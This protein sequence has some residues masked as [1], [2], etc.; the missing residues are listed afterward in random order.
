MRLHYSALYVPKAG[1]SVE[2]YEDSFSRSADSSVVAVS[3]GAGSA[4]ESRRWARMLTESFVQSPPLGMDSQGILDWSSQVAKW[5]SESIPW[6]QL[7]YFEMEKASTEGSAA[8]LVGLRFHESMPG[9]GTWQCIALGDSCVFQVSGGRLVDAI[10]ISKSADFGT[11]PPLFYTNRAQT[12]R[13]L[14]RLVTVDNKQWTAGDEF[15]LLTDA[16]AEWFLREA[17]CGREPW[18]TLAALNEESFGSFVDEQRFRDLLHNDDV[19]VVLLGTGDRK[20]AP[21][22]RPD[23]G[24]RIP[25]GAGAG[26]GAGTGAG[27]GAGARAGAGPGSRSGGAVASPNSTRYGA[28]QPPRARPGEGPPPRRRARSRQR[29]GALMIALVAGLL[30]GGLIG[31]AIGSGGTPTPAATSS[32]TPPESPTQSPTAAMES[33]ANQFMT[34]LVNSDGNL[35]NYETALNTYVAPGYTSQVLN[36]LN[37]NQKTFSAITSNG[38]VTFTVPGSAANTVYV[39]ATE[40]WSLNGKPQNPRF[41]LAQLTM[42]GAKDSW[43]V[44]GIAFQSAV[45]GLLPRIKNSTKSSGSQRGSI[46]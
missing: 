41:I 33:S 21:T 45:D 40:N 17:E 1:S 25:A 32:P 28:G 44:S 37:L 34:A 27:A 6:K 9:S 36:K 18:T 15:L 19:T 31:N 20:P 39:L 22:L 23:S 13:D 16:I 12:E 7:N 8:T 26:T 5:W 29:L 42:T 46:K 3:D 14:S 35:S 43:K 38:T 2:Q 4:F 11:R 30:I 24:A 10:P